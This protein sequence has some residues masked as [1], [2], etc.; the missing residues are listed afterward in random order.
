M[1]NGWLVQYGFNQT[2]Q[3]PYTLVAKAKHLSF[4]TCTQRAG[5]WWLVGADMSSHVSCHVTCARSAMH[6]EQA[7][8]KASLRTH[9]LRKLVHSSI[10]RVFVG[11]C[12]PVEPDVMMQRTHNSNRRDC[13]YSLCWY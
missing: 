7:L 1:R 10:F 12:V 3:D 13:V 4:C 2:K 8:I 5:T 11:V 6:T 9:A